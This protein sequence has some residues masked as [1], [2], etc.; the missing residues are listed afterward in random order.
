VLELRVSATEL[1]QRTPAAP[2]ISGGH[3]GMGREL[4]GAMRAHATGAEQG[5]TTFY[6]NEQERHDS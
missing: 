3:T 5:A 2:D 6:W 4:F 1:A